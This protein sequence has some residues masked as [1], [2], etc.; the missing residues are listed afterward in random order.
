M[1]ILWS[2]YSPFYTEI[3]FAFE[4][5]SRLEIDIR[6]GYAHHLSSKST[7]IDSCKLRVR[8]IEIHCLWAFLVGDANFSSNIL[9]L[10][11]LMIFEIVY[12]CSYIIVNY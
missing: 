3:V 9:I 1:L 10:N 5:Q 11:I 6:F 8:C 12:L 7:I 2:M 4:S